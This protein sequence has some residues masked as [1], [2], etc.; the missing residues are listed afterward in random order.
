M[1]YESISTSE[2]LRQFCDELADAPVI[3]F[4]TEFVSEDR[5]RPQLCLIQVAAGDRLAIIDPLAMESTD[6]F[7]DLLIQPGRTVIAHAAREESRFCYQFTGKPIAGLFDTQLAAGFSGMEFPISLGNLVHRLTGKTLT[8]GESRTNWRHRPLSTDQLRYALQ[9]VTDLQP[10]YRM[11]LDAI[12]Q[13]DREQWLVEE[14]EIR[15]QKVIEQETTENW[16]RVSG[17][18]GMTPRQ[19]EIIRH[20]WRWR[21]KRAEAQDRPVRRVMRDDLMVELAKRGS[22]DVK[23]IRSIRGM[24]WRGYSSNYDDIS[25]AIQAAIEVPDEDLPRRT[26]RS[27][28]VISPMLSQFLSTSLACISRQ[29]K[30]APSIVGNADDV[31]E[32]LGYELDPKE[33]DQVPSL[34]TGWRGEI[35]GKTFRKLLSG[36]AAIRVANV[37]QEQPLEFF[38]LD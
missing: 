31:K 26:R 17:C 37:R 21:D 2:E 6:P 25:A 7:W 35:V 15:Q 23:K 8:K 1:E 20:L 29:N 9:D 14:T 22:S 10:M 38:D 28:S 13:L 18:T 32:V 11:Q 24:D 34:L 5:Y 12:K 3:G 19:L 27:R 4:D 36:Q 16:R 30:L 33:G